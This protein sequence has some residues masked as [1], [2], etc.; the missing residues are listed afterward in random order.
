MKMLSA[1]LVTVML[2]APAIAQKSVPQETY[3]K[4]KAHIVAPAIKPIL[5]HTGKPITQADK[6]QFLTSAIKAYAAQVPTAGLKA[7]NVTVPATPPVLTP[8]NMNLNRVAYGIASLPEV[9]DYSQGEI[10]FKPGSAG[11]FIGDSSSLY[12]YIN[13]QPNTAYLV[14][15]KLTFTPYASNPQFTITGDFGGPPATQTSSVSPGTN[16]FVYAFISN[17]T[18]TV[19]LQ[20]FSSN[21]YWSFLSCEITATPMN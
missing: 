2:V 18:G 10:V 17:S 14:I 3:P 4:P 20:M 7:L 9:V 11:T 15:P 5:L 8:D 1:L 16:E 13:V 12:I 6:K 21:D 19:A